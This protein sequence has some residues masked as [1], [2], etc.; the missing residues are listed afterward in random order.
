YYQADLDIYDLGF[1]D[2]G[3][4]VLDVDGYNWDYSNRYFSSGIAEFGVFDY[5]T[6]AD[7]GHYSY[8]DFTDVE[9]TIETPQ[10]MYAYVWG[11]SFSGTEYSIQYRKIAE[12]DFELPD[13]VG[14]D[15]QLGTLYDDTFYLSSNTVYFGEAGN[16]TIYSGSYGDNQIAIGGD[17]NDTYKITGPGFLTIADLSSS[18]F[19][20][21]EA[22]GIGVYRPNTYFATVDGGRHLYLL[23]LDSFQSVIALDYQDPENRIEQIRASDITLTYDELIYSLSVSPNYIGDLTWTDVANLGGTNLTASQINSSID[24]YKAAWEL[25]NNTPPIITSLP[26]T[27]LNQGESFYYQISGYDADINDLITVVVETPSGTLPGWINFDAQNLILYGDAE[28]KD[29][30]EYRFS[31]VATDDKGGYDTQIFTLTVNNIND[32]PVFDFAP[33]SS[34][35]EDAAF[36]YQLTATD[37][38]ATVVNETLTYQRVNGPDWLNVSSTGLLSGTPTNDHIGTHSVTVQVTD[39]GGASDTKTFQLTVNNVND[40]PVFNFN[41]PVSIDEDIAF[42][43]Q[44]TASDI[45]VND[46]LTYQAINLP[47]WLSLSPTG[48]LSGTPTN[49]HVGTH[50]VSVEVR[51]SEGAADTRTFSLTVNNVN[52]APVFDFAAPASIDE[53][54]AFTLQLSAFDPDAI[55]GV[56]TLTYSEVTFPTW[57]S[58]SSDGLLQGTPTNDNVGT[59]NIIVRVTDEAGAFAEK[60][61]NL[62]VNNTNDPPIL[63]PFSGDLEIEEENLFSY[64][65]QVTD[66]DIG[67]EITFEAIDL[68]SWLQLSQ[69]GLL[70]GT[71]DDPD[72]GTHLVSVKA[73]DTSGASDQISFSLT[74]NNVNDAPVFNFDV[75]TNVNEDTLFSLELSAFDPDAENVDATL[76]YSE[77]TLPSWLSLSATGLLQGTP[78]NNNVGTHNIVVR[79]TDEAGVSAEKSFTLTVNNVNDPPTLEEIPDASLNEEEFFSYQLTANDIDVGDALSFVGVELPSWLSLSE[80]GLLS[81]TPDDPEI[82][83]H[84]IVV[85]A[86]DASG[87]AVQRQFSLT[88]N[89]VN[90][91][92]VF[93]FTPPSSADEDT[94]FSLS[95]SAVDSDSV[96]E[97]V[98]L[99]YTAVT[100]P[101]WLTLTSDGLLQGTPKNED[102]GDHSVTVQVTDTA[103]DTDTKTF[104]LTVNNTNDA[105]II[106]VGDTDGALADG[107]DGSA[108]SHQLSMTDVDVGDTHTY[109]MSSAD[110]ISW[111]SLDGSTGLLTGAPD[112]EQ[113]G[114]YNITFSVTDAASEV[115][116]SDTISLT[117]QNVNDPV[118]IDEGQASLFRS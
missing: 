45:D 31:I 28:N 118:Y 43:Y 99:T 61:F 73:T 34:T 52:D 44:L 18:T 2:A 6:T 48:L 17:G 82:G 20:V 58:L 112:D 51:D 62:T 65:L 57:L 91:V 63:Q 81:G 38:D 39:S 108:F 35:N 37:I 92:P 105:P 98:S 114:V 25:L 107:I 40:A 66:I 84:S 47:E 115:S 30:G 46:A 103:G 36:S 21:V 41:P 26:Q 16:D 74:V 13:P 23:D 76:S 94:S 102:V 75:P 89:N 8:N 33:P 55:N 87:E 110:N 101:T 85:Q 88:V 104:T 27:N 10:Q 69:L 19:D 80:T 106:V 14:F 3:T 53:D 42:S 113:V 29:V 24:Y 117:V 9:F 60:S 96:H 64:Q 15:E 111:L 83:T 72:I 77:V 4:Y 78:T 116:T 95:L 109:T 86:I 22:T 70:T 93:D 32:A 54:A 68:P 11:S 49:E 7:Y 50:S 12:P 97:E 5:T 56:G 90:D 100:L 79:V 59:H 71:P 1:L 67:D